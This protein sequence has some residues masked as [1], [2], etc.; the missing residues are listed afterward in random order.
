MS[1]IIGIAACLVSLYIIWAITKKIVMAV[2]F[3]LVVGGIVY[4]AIP[5]LAQRDDGVGK[6]AQKVN[7]VRKKAQ[8]KTIEVIKSPKTKEALE[9][10]KKKASDLANEPAVKKG[11]KA[12]VEAGKKVVE[13]GKKAVEAGKEAS[14]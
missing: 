2:F 10:A 7:E 12:T 1:M 9:A 4:V 13:A 8:D 11:V 5:M 14:K 3:A 6:A